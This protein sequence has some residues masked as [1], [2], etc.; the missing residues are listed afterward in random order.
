M[1]DGTC[2]LD[3]CASGW[4]GMVTIYTAYEELISESRVVTQCC[5]YTNTLY[6]AGTGLSTCSLRGSLGL[7]ERSCCTGTLQ[8]YLINRGYGA[9]ALHSSH[10]DS[11]QNLDYKGGGKDQQ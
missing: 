11:F 10:A 1:T 9:F 2:C 3:W 4:A 7:W 8:L 6:S 5:S